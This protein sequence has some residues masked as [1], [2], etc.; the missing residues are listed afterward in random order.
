MHK[1]ITLLTGVFIFSSSLAQLSKVSGSVNDPNEKRPV[2]NT[3]I[4]LLTF[5]DSILYKFTRSDAEGRYTIKD[6]K[7][8]SYILMRRKQNRTF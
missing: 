2:E 4:A 1:L 3:V 5:K 8:G 7:P 6:I